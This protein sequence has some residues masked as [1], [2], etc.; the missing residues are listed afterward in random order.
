MVDL[1][2]YKSFSLVA[3]CIDLMYFH[4]MLNQ[5]VKDTELVLKKKDEKEVS[6]CVRDSITG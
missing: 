6:M 3:V 4:K 2:G 5:A 1:K